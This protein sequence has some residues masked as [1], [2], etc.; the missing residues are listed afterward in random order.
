M[1]LLP[2][3]PYTPEVLAVYCKTCEAPSGAKCTMFSEILG[4]VRELREPHGARVAYSKLAARR[5]GRRK[6]GAT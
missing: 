6:P 5:K 4:R 1:P 3:D 2:R